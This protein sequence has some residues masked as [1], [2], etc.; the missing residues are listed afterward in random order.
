MILE[1]YIQESRFRG[2]ISA[3]LA[4][5]FHFCRRVSQEHCRHI[6]RGSFDRMCVDASLFPIFRFESLF[7]LSHDISGAFLE[8]SQHSPGDSRLIHAAM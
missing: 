7:Q 3:S 5:L 8:P 4:Q 1:L 2:G 6:S